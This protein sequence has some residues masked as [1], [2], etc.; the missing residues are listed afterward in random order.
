MRYVAVLFAFLSVWMLTIVGHGTAHAQLRLNEL[1]A[2]PVLDWDGDGEVNSRS[3]EW[4]EII[5]LGPDT[6]NL[7]TYRLADA[8][9][10][11]DWRFG[12]EG[13]LAPGE[14]RVVYG[15][16]ATAWQAATGFPLAGLSLNNGGDTATLFDTAGGDTIAVDSYTYSGF[17]VLDDR[18]VGRDPDNRAWVI[19]D[20]LNPYAGTTPPLGTGCVPTPGGI[21]T[22]SDILPVEETTW[23]AVKE[24]YGR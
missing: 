15:S 9:G 2:D 16:D 22:C 17:E 24:L 23:G 3:D 6:V 7:S 18:A 19:F 8:A 10:G 12:F 1:L 4:V 14:V 5:N 13:V 21:N 20:A 11:Y